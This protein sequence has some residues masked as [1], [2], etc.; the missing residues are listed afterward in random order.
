MGGDTGGRAGPKRLAARTGRGPG[1][2][3][4]KRWL[5]AGWSVRSALRRRRARPRI[6]Y[7]RGRSSPSRWFV[8]ELRVVRPRGLPPGGVER[9]HCLGVPRPTQWPKRVSAGTRMGRGGEGRPQ[10][11]TDRIVLGR[12][13]ILWCVG[14]S[15]W[16]SKLSDKESRRGPP[17]QETCSGRCTLLVLLPGQIMHRG[18]PG[19]IDM[20]VTTVGECIKLKKQ[21]PEASLGEN[22]VQ[23]F[24]QRASACAVG[25]RLCAG[26]S[27]DRVAEDRSA[28]IR[29]PSIG[30]APHWP[31]S[32]GDWRGVAAAGAIAGSRRPRRALRADDSGGRRCRRVAARFVVSARVGEDRRTV[33]NQRAALRLRAGAFTHPRVRIQTEGVL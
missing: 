30:G 10:M 3:H 25:R 12:I 23:L 1:T 32:G 7:G 8:Q 21:Q 14:V 31:A 20:H 5:F 13:A 4:T 22:I 17:S 29:R 33:Q 15:Q 24:F 27:A 26:G 18:E 16:R 28:R 11:I 19:A 6:R 2:T 9:R